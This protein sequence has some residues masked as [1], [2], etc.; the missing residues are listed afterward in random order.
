MDGIGRFVGVYLCY[1]CFLLGD[2]YFICY[3]MGYGGNLIFSIYLV[4]L[5]VYV[6]IR[7][8]IYMLFNFFK[9]LF[10]VFIVYI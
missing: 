10:V 2:D 3:R 7:G 8:K 4:F 1:V 5:N 9:N 6:G